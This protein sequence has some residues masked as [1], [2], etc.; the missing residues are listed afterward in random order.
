VVS[1]GAFLLRMLEPAVRPDSRSTQVGGL[2]PA[3]R[4]QAVPFEQR[5]FAV[6]LS[7]AQEAVA[8]ADQVAPAADVARTA[9][10]PLAPLAQIDRIE[11]QA[12]RDMIS[13]L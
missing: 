3:A 9:A 8:A 13:Q 7:Q 6:L 5:D 12:L 11:N 4:Q 2:T 1:D 10:S